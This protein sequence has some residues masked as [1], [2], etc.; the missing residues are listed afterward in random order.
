MSHSTISAAALEAQRQREI[1]ARIRAEIAEI[2]RKTKELEG[3]SDKRKAAPMGG[4]EIRVTA[5]GADEEKKAEI[6]IAKEAVSKERFT[7]GRETA[8][9][10]FSALLADDPE[11]LSPVDIVIAEL[12]DMVLPEKYESERRRLL[13]RF[14]VMREGILDEDNL[15]RQFRVELTDFVH[16]VEKETAS[17]DSVY[18][19]Y[20]IICGLLGVKPEKLSGEELK[21]AYNRQLSRLQ[22]REERAYILRGVKAVL[23]NHGYE[24]EGT[25]MLEEDTGELFSTEKDSDC[26]VFVA[27]DG[28]TFI[29]EALADETDSLETQKEIENAAKKCCRMNEIIK[30]ECK[31]KGILI[32]FATGTS[33]SYS[34]MKKEKDCKLI[35]AAVDA[36]ADDAK[37]NT[38]RRIEHRKDKE[39]EMDE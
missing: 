22:K 7:G 10:D 28:N 26:K 39:R 25:A 9:D 4:Y 17:D 1:E 23:R 18:D 24:L 8:A 13:E 38:S 36:N 12:R 15:A 19:E 3:A 37:S 11:P 5:D 21:T 30:E 33:P 29:M 6:T 20:V 2:R 16:R 31:A 27:M 34:E 35:T 14:Q 32:E